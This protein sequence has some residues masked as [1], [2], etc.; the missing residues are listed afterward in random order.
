MLRTGNDNKQRKADISALLCLMYICIYTIIRYNVV[1]S[2][3]SLR[4]VLLS[5]GAQ[6]VVIND[7]NG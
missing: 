5:R 2:F 1:I 7:S 3:L 4:K 6:V